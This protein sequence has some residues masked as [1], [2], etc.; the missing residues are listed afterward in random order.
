VKATPVEKGNDEIQAGGKVERLRRKTSKGAVD[1][2]TEIVDLNGPIRSF[3]GE[4]GKC[5]VFG[6]IK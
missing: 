3:K 2:W 5:P 1:P 4:D 6:G